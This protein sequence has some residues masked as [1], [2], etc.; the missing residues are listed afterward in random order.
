MSKQKTL[1]S[2][3]AGFSQLSL[4]KKA[5]KK[6]N[7][8]IVDKNINSPAKKYASEFINESVEDSKKI[9]KKIKNLQISKKNIAGIINRCSGNSILTMTIL[10]K[11]LLQDHSNLYFIKKLLDKNKFVSMCQ[12]KKILIPATYNLNNLKNKIK[13]PVIIKPSK[14]SIGKTGIFIAK[15]LKELKKKLVLSRK[16]S[17]D[18]KVIIQKF[19]NGKDIVVIGA[20]KKKKFY[21]LGVIDEINKIQNNSIKRHCFKYPSKNMNE[22]DRLKIINITKNIIK[23][24]KIDNTPIN[25]S[26]RIN[27]KNI[28]LIEINL[29]ISGELIHEKLFKTKDN[30]FS[31][32]D[33]YLNL[34]FDKK[35]FRTPNL[36][37]NKILITDNII[38]KFYAKSI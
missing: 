24:L 9:I 28:Y 19:I 21:L 5:K 36:K 3:G 26:F 20:V 30:V 17:Q 12:K 33:W 18:K 27:N 15:N 34:F 14:A 2:L 13:F 37:K 38:K 29:E 10:Q 25:L 16:F 35:K 8:I 1:I 22:V 31:S 23:K 11:Y 7:L 4:I 32:F 6:F